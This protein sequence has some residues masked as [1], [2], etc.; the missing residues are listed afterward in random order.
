MPFRPLGRLSLQLLFTVFF[1][2]FTLYNLVAIFNIYSSKI[3]IQED[4]IVLDIIQLDKNQTPLDSTEVLS[5]SSTD[6]VALNE[7]KQ[8]AVK[9]L[10]EPGRSAEFSSNNCVNTRYEEEFLGILNQYRK[11]NGKNTLVREEALDIAA[12]NHSEW[13]SNAMLLSHTGLNN[14]SPSTRCKEVGTY[15]DAE[16]IATSS[17][18]NSPQRLF[19]LYKNS[20]GHNAN[21]LGEHVV[22]GIA[23][24]GDYQT[25]VFR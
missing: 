23:W 3:Q 24:A 10:T 21:M 2:L 8:E 17:P 6:V 12:C 19:E 4:T 14:S 20:P 18:D 16:N 5:E 7:P 1:F 11:T 22:V 25:T 9:V 13:M 15:C